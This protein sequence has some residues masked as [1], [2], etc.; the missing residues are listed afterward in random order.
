MNKLVAL[1]LVLVCLLCLVGCNKSLEYTT[2][3][4]GRAY[5]VLPISKEQVRVRS[6]YEAYLNDIDYGMLKKAEEKITA[7]VSQYGSGSDFYLQ[8][9]NDYLCLYKEIIVNVDPPASEDGEYILGGCGVD[10]KHL[11]F[12]ERITK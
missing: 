5:L 2:D 12:G 9:D 6:E 10:H 1:A 3:E 7:Q 4:K 8:L 11:F